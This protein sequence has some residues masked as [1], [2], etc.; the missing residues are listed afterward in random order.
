MTRL[1]DSLPAW[2]R[3]LPAGKAALAEA[4]AAERTEFSQLAD[5]LAELDRQESA[6][7]AD[8]TKAIRTAEQGLAKVREALKAAEA[9]LGSAYSAS[10]GA[11]SSFESRRLQLKR[12]MRELA[13]GRVDAFLAE[14]RREHG[15]LRRPDA[16]ET[17]EIDVAD[18]D[19]TV[20]R[21]SATNAAS[22]GRRLVAIVVA[23]RAAE[24]LRF[25]TG[26]VEAALQ[27]LR[28]GLPAV[29]RAEPPKLPAAAPRRQ[30]AYDRRAARFL[31]MAT[32]EQEAA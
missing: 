11:S 28:D 20:L 2:F 7:A 25:A 17:I 29:E 32:A 4:V 31:A 8:R 12:Q 26:D 18:H 10:M 30:T 27:K 13:D 14:M 1:R 6:G 3:D 5:Q 23:Q 16:I 24:E 22:I 15:R 9:K 19:G 21:L